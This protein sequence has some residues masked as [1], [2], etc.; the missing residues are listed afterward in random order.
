MVKIRKK[1]KKTKGEGW[2]GK[3]GKRS[4]EKEPELK[5]WREDL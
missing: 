5:T 3:A 4:E 2:V 1:K